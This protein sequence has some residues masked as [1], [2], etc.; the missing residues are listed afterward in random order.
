MRRF[1]LF[2]IFLH[3]RCSSVGFPCDLWIMT[4]PNNLHIRCAYIVASENFNII[5]IIGCTFLWVGYVN[6]QNCYKYIIFICPDR[7]I[8]FDVIYRSREFIKY[9]LRYSRRKPNLYYFFCCF[10]LL[11]RYAL[12][13]TTS[14]VLS[15]YWKLINFVPLPRDNCNQLT[16]NIRSR[17]TRVMRE[18]NKHT[19][20]IEWKRYETT[21]KRLNFDRIVLHSF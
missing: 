5:N 6:I 13:R 14:G 17:I 7:R 9:L 19:A 3:K 11:M 12:L 8:G 10:N 21:N 4:D 20:A 16:V 2:F 1:M 15:E 18:I